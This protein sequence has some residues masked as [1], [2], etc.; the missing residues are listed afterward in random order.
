MA[1]IINLRMARKAKTR[2]AARHEADANRARHG[3]TRAE[4]GAA[5]A[6]AARLVRVVDGAKR[7]RSEEAGEKGTD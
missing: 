7:E 4:R 1:D 3:R 6:E 5:E 2:D